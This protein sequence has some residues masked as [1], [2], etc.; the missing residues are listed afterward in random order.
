[1]AYLRAYVHGGRGS[2]GQERKPRPA[3]DP[4]NKREKNEVWGTCAG[5]I[6]LSED[7][8]NSVGQGE[9]LASSLAFLQAFAKHLLSIC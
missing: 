1:M 2:D 8:V 9:L 7:V 4:G 5:C 3:R 6:L